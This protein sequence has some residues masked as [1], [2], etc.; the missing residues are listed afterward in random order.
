MS[1]AE[2]V[3][4]VRRA[5]HST[6][7]LAALAGS[8]MASR[9]N[10]ANVTLAWDASTDPTVT[11]YR[12]YYG[13]ATGIYTNLLDAGPATSVTVSNL[14]PAT[15]YHFAATT[16]NL[17]GMESVYSTE[18]AY[19][20]PAL[21]V[22]QPPTIDPISDVTISMNSGPKT[23]NLTG[24]TSGSATENQTL[25]VN[26]FSSNPALLPTPTV[27][28]SSPNTTGTL[29]FT[30]AI[31]S[32]G[33]VVMTVMVDDGGSISNTIIRTFG[34]TVVA[35]PPLT[36]AIITPNSVFAYKLTP[37]VA[38]QDQFSYSLGAGAPAGVSIMSSK[39][40]GPLLV[41][42]PDSSQAS[43]TNLISI[44]VTDLTNPAF[45][46]NQTLMVIVQDYLG[47]SAGWTAAQ[48]G[49]TA[50]VPLTLNCSEGIT[51]AV[52]TVGWPGNNF[53]NPSLTALSPKIA[54][55]S[56]QNQGTNLLIS[57]QTSPNQGLQGSNLVA[58]V[59]FQIASNQPSAFVRLPVAI[60][61]ANK[62]NGTAYANYFPQQGRVA[63]V[64]DRPL[65]Q[66]SPTGS[67]NL[68]LTLFG[69]VGATYQLFYTSNLTSTATWY[70]SVVY[71]QTNV[72]QP[73]S[74]GS[75]G[76]FVTYRLRQ[77]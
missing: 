64:N 35:P 77:L 41:W 48:V 39:K 21:P 45:S 43:T 32:Y 76:G 75:S 72:A 63:V 37:P 9:T 16:Y 15:T 33:V 31:N 66:A 74:V 20:V 42:K 52:F 25:T 38:N 57:L 40:T 67:S 4:R 71:S 1:P 47:V 14:G 70:P 44:I 8:L 62:P 6:F 61:T 54:S 22:N 30:P 2:V 29:S 3:H 26:A 12:L 5:A 46:T 11:G 23:V 69:K 49:Q 19:T 73:L 10:A 55:S 59:S 65:M 27:N 34:V 53:T 17:A 56:L 51:S 13:L 50:V 58:Q 18:V 68:S 7:I 36:N 60:V 24:I 28:Y